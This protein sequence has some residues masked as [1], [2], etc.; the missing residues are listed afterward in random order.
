MTTR[1]QAPGTAVA[2][3]AANPGQL[4]LPSDLESLFE[5]D[6]GVGGQDIAAEDKS[7]PFISLAQGLS[8]QLD[9]SKP[10]YL[11][12]AKIGSIFNTVTGDVYAGAVG[13]RVIPVKVQK[14]WNKWITRAAGGGFLGSYADEELS[15]PI[16]VPPT[17]DGTD[18]KPFDIIETMNWYVLAEGP[19][20]TWAPAVIAMK[21]TQLKASRDWGTLSDSIRAKWATK[22]G[23]APLYGYI[24]TVRSVSQTNDKGTFANY[25][26]TADTLPDR[27]LY[28]MARDFRKLLDIGAVE[29]N[30]EKSTAAPEAAADVPQN[31]DGTAQY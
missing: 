13:A 6:A 14:F 4:T 5:A 8:P 27:A 7:I 20:G 24:Y 15:V 12:A 11:E 29:V 1:T 3:T 16:F 23:A 22:S 25:K 2:K 17:R 9:P 31:P 26:I 18:E 19:D 10:G 28:L 30:M 21:V